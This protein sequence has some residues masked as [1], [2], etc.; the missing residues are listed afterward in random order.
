MIDKNS[1]TLSRQTSVLWG[2]SG[3]KDSDLWLPLHLHLADT[4]AIARILWDE[5]VP[6]GTKKSIAKGVIGI[7]PS[8]KQKKTFEL[9]CFIFILLSSFH[10]IGKAIPAFQAAYR[11]FFRESNGDTLAYY[12]KEAGLK[13]VKLLN[14]NEIHH[15]LASYSILRRHGWDASFAVIAGAHHGKPPS[16][17]DVEKVTDLCR[18]STGFDDADWIAVQDE[19]VDW[20]ESL[21]PPDALSLVKQIRLTRTA[22]ILLTGLLIMADWIASDEQ[23]FPLIETREQTES[24]DTRALEAWENLTLE[25][26][27]NIFGIQQLQKINDVYKE[28]FSI[29]KPYP[30]QTAILDALSEESEPGIV[31]IEAP[32][33]EGKTEAALAAAE[34]LAERTGRSGI[35]FAL[36][37]QATSDGIFPR[38]IKW[39]ETLEGNNSIRLVHGKAQFNKDFQGLGF[40]SNSVNEGRDAVFVSDWAYGRKRALLNDFVVGTIDQVLMAGLQQKHVM[41]RHLGLANKVVIIDECHAYDTYMNQYLCKTLNWLGSYQVPVIVLSATLPIDRRKALIEAYLN[42][43]PQS[44]IEDPLFDTPTSSEE[45]P[46]WAQTTAYPLITFT[47]G[48]EVASVAPSASARKLTVIIEQLDDQNIVTCLKESLRHGGCAGGIVNTVSRAQ[49]LA[50]E[51]TEAFDEEIVVLLHSRFTAPDRIKKE[52]KVRECLGPNSSNR[53]EKLIVIGTQVLEQSLDIDFDMMISDICPMDLLI[54]RIGRLHRHNR[55]ERPALLQKARCFVT[56]IKGNGEFQK[57][58]QLVYGTYML[59]NTQALL[60]EQ[61]ALPDDIS[62]LVQAAYDSHGVSVPPELMSQYEK[63]KCEY[64][65]EAAQA[66]AKARVFQ[67]GTPQGGSFGLLSTIV[68]LLYTDISDR[69]PSG[70]RAEATVRD[71]TDSVQVLVVQRKHNGTLYLPTWNAEFGGSLLPDDFSNNTKLAQ[72]LAQNV[73]TLPVNMTTPWLIDKVITVFEKDCYEKLPSQWQD[74]PWLEGELFLI[75]NENCEADLC[76]F[77]LHY[78]ERYGLSVERLEGKGGDVC[79]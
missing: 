47:K 60:P 13:F 50:R 28:R 26:Y 6:K 55:Y 65:D 76:G 35:F 3:P 22:Q 67:I 10:D 63:A 27:Q 40:S 62:N 53:P 77:R 12:V 29:Q 17:A 46:V 56:G 8:Y 9:L 73:V 7:P 5:W 32:M 2:K 42:S 52:A 66:T 1:N 49:T 74:S 64:E 48:E 21:I 36:P 54:Q 70:K 69:D 78:D 72:V 68:D 25:P 38:I 11:S 20:A 33:G 43:Q 57:G 61:I 39:V 16:T 15:S 37:T 4:A 51:L 30:I 41:L 59:M 14:P 31:I 79:E 45:P 58:S 19:L 34:L 18:N 23:L 71:S 44:V 75:L 24:S